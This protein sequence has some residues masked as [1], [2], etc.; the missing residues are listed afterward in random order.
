MSS[1]GLQENLLRRNW[2]LAPPAE[3]FP[4]P[5]AAGVPGASPSI[6]LP[7]D[8]QAERLGAALVDVHVQLGLQEASVQ[9]RAACVAAHGRSARAR[10]M[11]GAAK[12]VLGRGRGN[13]L[14]SEA[15]Q[16]RAVR[17]RKGWMPTEVDE[18]YH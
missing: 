3:H 14:G 7:F 8:L 1:N 9:Q 16:R 13:S 2:L 4:G 5:T 18:P 6:C 11:F 17:K 15:V 12:E 10:S